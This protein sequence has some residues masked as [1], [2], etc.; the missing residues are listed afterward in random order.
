MASIDRMPIEKS[1]IVKG[2]IA[3]IISIISTVG[4]GVILFW[5]ALAAIFKTFLPFLLIISGALL[6]LVYLYHYLHY[7]RYY[8]D[9]DKEYLII[10]EGVITYSETTIPY[11]RIQ[12]VYIDQDPLDQ[13]F[14]LYDLHV[15]T[16]SGQSS[17]NAHIDGLNYENA[18]KVKMEILK[19]LKTK[20]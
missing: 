9:L 2:T 6:L 20:K 19:R 4:V 13:I 17:V 1:K 14:G 16:A 3:T 10:K 7:R 18:Q 15:A 5:T 8:Y 11:Y 12:D